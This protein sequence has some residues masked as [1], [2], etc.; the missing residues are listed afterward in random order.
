[1]YRSGIGFVAFD[2]YWSYAG[3]APESSVI[4]YLR[5]PSRKNVKYALLWANHI[6]QANADKEWDRMV[7]YWLQNHLKNPEYLQV[8]GSPV[9]FVFSG[10][11]LRDNAARSGTTVRQLIATAQAMARTAGLNGIYFV[12]CTPALDYWVRTFAQDAGFSALS[13]YNYHYGLSGSVDSATRPSQSFR[14]LDA[15]Y[16]MQWNWILQNST[17][18]YFL[19]MSSGWDRRPWGGSKDD[20]LHDRSMS[21]LDEFDQH[22]TAARAIM[23]AHPKKTKRMGIICC[24]NEFGEGSYIEPTKREG[25]GYLDVVRKVFGSQK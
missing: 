23:D 5:A 7:A 17:L 4:A 20:P 25:F 12:L 10:D 9:V 18:P 3:P 14:E 1:M 8:E 21:T 2:W 11:F 15:G 6:Q 24:W 13:A 19:P 22:L 16:R